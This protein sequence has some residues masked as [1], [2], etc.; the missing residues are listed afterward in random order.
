[1]LLPGDGVWW[2]AERELAGLSAP[3]HC[4]LLTYGTKEGTGWMENIEQ[5]RPRAVALTL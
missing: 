3:A 5:A 1:M 4:A 2:V